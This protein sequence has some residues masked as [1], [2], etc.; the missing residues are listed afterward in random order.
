MHTHS[1]TTVQTKFKSVKIV[2]DE[3]NECKAKER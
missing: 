2:R 1:K 3:E